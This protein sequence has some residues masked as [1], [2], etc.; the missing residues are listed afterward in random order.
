MRTRLQQAIADF[1]RH[2]CVQKNIAHIW[3]APLVRFADARH[4]LF[5]QLKKVALSE[6]YLPEDY[7]PEARIVI[8]YFLPFVRDMARTNA[9]WGASSPQWAEAYRTACDMAIDL[10]EHLAALLRSE[11]VQVCVPHNALMI[12]G[13]SP[14]SYWSQ[15]HVA[16]IAGHGTFGL[17]NMLISDQG[18]VGR[19]YSLVTN[20]DVAADPIVEE[21]RCLFK[22]NGSCALCV[23]RCETGA[24]KAQGFD[25]F[26]CLEQC[27]YNAALYAGAKICGKCVVELPCSYS[28]LCTP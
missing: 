14:W 16:Y 25:R 18:T 12:G 15:R 6:H 8:S 28:G 5:A 11:D 7:L 9:E 1:I 4:P 2:Y 19:Y 21:Q 10:N 13:E 22:K 24:L 3:Q 27:R 20:L 26:K 17:N 23:Q